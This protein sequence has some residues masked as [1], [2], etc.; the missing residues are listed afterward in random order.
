M[1]SPFRFHTGLRINISGTLKMSGLS[2]VYSV[3]LDTAGKHVTCL[4]AANDP[5]RYAYHLPGENVGRAAVLDIRHEA[6]L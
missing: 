3:F 4:N 6:V 2:G 1:A 5:R